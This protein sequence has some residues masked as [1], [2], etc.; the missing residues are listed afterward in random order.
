[1]SPVRRQSL[2]PLNGATILC[3]S[4]DRRLEPGQAAQPEGIDE[5]HVRTL[6]EAGPIDASGCLDVLSTFD[7]LRALGLPAIRPGGGRRPRKR[8]APRPRR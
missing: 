7:V 2:R 5:S 3:T 1:M 8:R 6:L 4:S